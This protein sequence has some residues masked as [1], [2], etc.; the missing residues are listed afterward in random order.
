[1]SNRFSIEHAGVGEGHKGVSFEFKLSGGGDSL[2]TPFGI[3]LGI[4]YNQRYMKLKLFSDVEKD[5]H[6]TARVT[7]NHS[8]F[9]GTIITILNDL[10]MLRLDLVN[11]FMLLP[12]F[13]FTSGMVVGPAMMKKKIGQETKFGI[14]ARILGFIEGVALLVAAQVMAGASSIIGPIGT[15]DRNLIII[16]VVAAAF[17][18]AVPL[19]R[20]YLGWTRYRNVPEKAITSLK[21]SVKKFDIRDISKDYKQ[22]LKKYRAAPKNT[23]EEE[24]KAS[25]ELEAAYKVLENKVNDV[26]EKAPESKFAKWLFLGKWARI[27][28][29]QARGFWAAIVILGAFAFVSIP[30]MVP[31]SFGPY[32]FALPI[33][34]LVTYLFYGFTSITFIQVYGKIVEAIEAWYW[35]VKVEKLRGKVDKLI[36]PKFKTGE[37]TYVDNEIEWKM[38]AIEGLLKRKSFYFVELKY[39]EVKDLLKFGDHQHVIF[40]VKVASNP[41]AE[42]DKAM[43]APQQVKP[44]VN[45]RIAKFVKGGIDLSKTVVSVNAPNGGIQITFNDPEML[46]LLLNADGLAPI[47]YDVKVMTPAMADHFV[48]V[49]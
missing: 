26:L 13:T 34:D 49:N 31:V 20:S 30:P 7:I 22:A 1:M 14:G 41:S 23:P 45:N 42:G 35:K 46:R 2:F 15:S 47:I 32:Q 40:P 38:G 33:K 10:V 12:S 6:V 29:E 24:A 11:V 21:R 19:I 17:A 27:F 37:Y 3:S 4:L 8:I 25:K 9:L 44:V 28:S 48:G 16:G 39:N 5:K 43:Q 36:N 18:N